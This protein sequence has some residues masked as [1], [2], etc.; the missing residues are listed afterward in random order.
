MKIKNLLLLASVMML[1]A[2][3]GSKSVTPSTT[4]ESSET[5]SESSETSESTEESSSSS[6]TTTDTGPKKVTVAAHTL[7]DTNPPIN[8]NSPGEQVTKSVWD[9]FRYG[10]EAKFKGNYN[11][12]YWSY[13][14]GYE[15]IE[16][17]TKNGY[18]MKSI[19][20]KLYY[21]RKSG[22]TFYTYISQSDGYLRQETT[23]DL[24][25]KY[26]SR[27]VNEIYVHMFDY[28]NYEFQEYDGTYRY[29]DYG[30]GCGVKFQGGYLTYLFYS[31]G[32]SL[33]EIRATFETTID[34]PKSYYYE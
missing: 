2:G 10:G 14:G 9:S 5:V 24:Q 20:G 26:T 7:K 6:E 31:V 13:S 33:F 18:Y 16:A 22:S 34:I 8:V 29:I 27:I 21:E 17:F 19:A 23:L 4:E 28:E 11:Y 30:F 3:C 1:I 12:T 32:G 25:S 15:T